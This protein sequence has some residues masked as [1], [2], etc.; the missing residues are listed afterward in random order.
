MPRLPV[1]G[2]FVVHAVACAVPPRMCAFE[3]DCG[4]R[5]S[6][7]AGRCVAHG[8]TAAV[9]TA[10]RLLFS[11]VD[12]VYVGSGEDGRDAVVAT[13][14]RKRSASAALLLRFSAPLPPE[15]NLLEAYVL[16]ER[17]SDIDADPTP[18]ALRAGRVLD[19][20]DSGTVS[21]S[22]RPRVDDS[23]APMTRVFL[24]GPS[25]VRLDVRELVQR[26]RRRSGDDFG[27]AVLAEGESATGVAFALAP[28][29]GTAF[30]GPRL[31]LYVK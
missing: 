30:A 4:G 24:S 9:D 15:A 25:L 14:G 6:C 11:P 27:V 17:A 29:G 31:E 12:V 7:V 28:V 16:L 5:A 1:L 2:L 26:W 18:V 3:S 23:G 10:R 8:A 19:P 20:W 21:A 13:L 22:R